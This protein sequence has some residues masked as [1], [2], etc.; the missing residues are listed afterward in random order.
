MRRYMEKKLIPIFILVFSYG[1]GASADGKLISEKEKLTKEAMNKI[2]NCS[3]EFSK[4]HADHSSFLSKINFAL[5]NVY[6][7]E[8][9]TIGT[10]WLR[11][12]FYKLVTQ[13][14]PASDELFRNELDLALNDL[15]RFKSEISSNEI[16]S[17]ATIEQYGVISN[18]G[19]TMGTKPS[20]PKL[21]DYTN[22]SGN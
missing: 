1:V 9:M 21:P 7:T 20:M 4:K 12:S 8:C 13:A 2:I 10:D 6:P 5:S 15:Q 19:Q 3:E 22:V 16:F 14:T 17:S 18:G 11:K